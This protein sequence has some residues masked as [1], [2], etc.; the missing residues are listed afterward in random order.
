MSKIQ[1]LR[2]MNDI[3]PKQVKEWTFVE[4]VIKSVVESYGYEEIRFPVVEKTELYTRS[5]AVSYTHL[6]LPTILLV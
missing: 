5:N 6:T 2:G 4:E 1:T 3:H